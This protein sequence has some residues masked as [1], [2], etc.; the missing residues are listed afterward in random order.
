VEG[1]LALSL[2]LLGR[3]PA[4]AGGI[5]AAWLH[6]RFGER[7]KQAAQAAPWM[8]RGGADLVLAG[9]ALILGLLLARVARLGFWDAEA[10]WHVWHLYEAALWTAILLVL[11]LAPLR[12]RRLLAGGA[13]ASVGIVSYS[14]YLWHYP[15]LH[16]VLGPLRAAGA[17]GPGWSAQGLAAA[18]LGLVLAFGVS[19]VTYR[20]VER[21]FLARKARIGG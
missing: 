11:L 1:Q 21:P 16:A 13:L 12:S 10:H 19:T 17:G 15:T 3:A 4:F 8:R 5:A 9:L 14:L 2:S 18:T 20:F 6:E 7:L